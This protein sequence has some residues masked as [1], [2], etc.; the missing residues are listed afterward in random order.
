MLRFMRKYATGYLVKTIF[1]LII[2]V[3]IFWGV[4]SY[5]DS[6]QVVAEVGP[7]KVT[8]AEYRDAYNKHIEF[9][10]MVYRD[11]FD[12]DMVK[13]LKLRE[14]A[15][16]SLVDQYLLMGIAGN[17]GLAVSDREFA[18][19]IGS[20]KEF[21]R[22]G[23]FDQKRYVEI[24][25]R[26]NTDPQ[27]FE[28]EQK[29]AML[30]SKVAAILGTLGASRSDKELYEQFVK[31]RGKVDLT[32][33]VFDPADYKQKAEIKETDVNER[34][35]K[36]K[37]QYKSENTYFL[38]EIIIDGKSGMK[39][40]Q[41]YLDLIKTKDFEGYVKQKG[42]Q[43]IDLGSVKESDLKK[44]FTTQQSLN[45]I[46]ELKK[47][48]IS[49]PVR[50]GGKSSIYVL[51][52]REEGKPLE[53]TVVLAEI[54]EKMRLEKGRELAK[55]AAEDGAKQK[56]AGKGKETGLMNRASQAIPGIGP[57]PRENSEVFTLS[58]AKPVYE[59]PVFIN[60]KY[61]V[62]FF[63]S[64]KQPDAADWEKEK[65]IF[66]QSTLAKDR[67]DFVKAR[68]EDSKKKEKVKVFWDQI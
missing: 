51:V 31:Q 29:K 9:F 34:Y 61:Y 57:V 33:V 43:M 56:S 26:N 17:L 41:A 24:L 65:A 68:V 8:M 37:G 1:G 40:D 48:E 53:K 52:N 35:E 58:S 19:Y 25:K 3:F 10:R 16:E 6:D 63:K 28:K 22:D 2:V 42:L 20:M 62:F 66:K 60:G 14:K 11:K 4:G 55:S 27:R 39:D 7:Y 38:K 36:E 30:I 44:R 47:G 15:M 54:K 13:Q 45:A 50:D 49:L 18:D 23:K 5:R 12:E 67:D 64:E 21:Q 46:K 59:K 32:F